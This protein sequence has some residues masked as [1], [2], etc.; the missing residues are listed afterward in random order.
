MVAVIG[1]WKMGIRWGWG[2]P[3]ICCVAANRLIGKITKVLIFSCGYKIDFRNSLQKLKNDLGELC[4]KQSAGAK[5]GM[6]AKT[7]S[8][9]LPKPSFYLKTDL[10]KLMKGQNPVKRIGV[11]FKVGGENIDMG[12]ATRYLFAPF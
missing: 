5:A 8:A 9:L 2:L 4:A 6:A 10:A 7:A 12:G 11:K 1:L 3:V